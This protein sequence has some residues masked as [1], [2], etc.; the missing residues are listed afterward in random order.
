MGELRVKRVKKKS[1]FNLKSQLVCF[2]T[3][4][5]SGDYRASGPIQ[6]TIKLAKLSGKSLKGT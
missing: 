5:E 2:S 4:R 6:A 3:D 1:S